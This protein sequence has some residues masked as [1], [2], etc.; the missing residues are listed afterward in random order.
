MPEFQELSREPRSSSHL[1]ETRANPSLSRQPLSIQP[2]PKPYQPI[3]A[4]QNIAPPVSYLPV[5]PTQ[6]MQPVQ[7]QPV[8]AVQPIPP[9]Q[10]QPIQPAQPVQYQPA[11]PAQP[12][13]PVQPVQYQQPIQPVQPPINSLYQ[14]PRMPG[15]APSIPLGFYQTAAPAYPINNNNSIPGLNNLGQGSPN[16]HN[17]PQTPAPPAPEIKLFENMVPV[18]SR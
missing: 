16:R 17:P 9:V 2:Q 15:Q 11:Q 1:Q 8:Q 3:P 5:Q 4:I 7:Y 18:D 6:P 12:L 14:Q 10:Y 13:P